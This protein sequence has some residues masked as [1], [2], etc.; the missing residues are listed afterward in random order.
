MLRGMSLWNQNRFSDVLNILPFVVKYVLSKC[1]DADN[2]SI[3]FSD[4]KK[5]IYFIKILV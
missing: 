2:N 3:L 5:N 1:I 4:K